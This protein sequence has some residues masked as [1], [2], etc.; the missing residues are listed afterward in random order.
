MGSCREQE[1]AETLRA[2]RSRVERLTLQ[3]AGVADLGD[4]VGA[5]L[6]QLATVRDSLARAGE[7]AATAPPPQTDPPAAS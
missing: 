7:A 3:L 6:E 1:L 2:E 4:S 5:A